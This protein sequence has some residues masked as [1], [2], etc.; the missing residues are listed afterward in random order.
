MS[1]LFIGERLNGG[2]SPFGIGEDISVPQS[3]SEAKIRAEATLGMVVNAGIGGAIGYGV[4]SMMKKNPQIGVVAGS[5]ITAGLLSGTVGT[6]FMCGLFEDK[7][8]QAR[9]DAALLPKRLVKGF[10]TAAVTA[11][12]GYFGS[13]IKKHPVAGAFAGSALA[14]GIFHAITFSSECPKVEGQGSS[15]TIG[16]NP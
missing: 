6:G 13:K 1:R 9:I 2:I 5:A 8:T 15:F 10:G 11:T 12:A 16:G 14:S 3:P 4:A 7:E